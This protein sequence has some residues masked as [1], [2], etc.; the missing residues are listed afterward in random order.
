MKMNLVGILSTK[1]MVRTIDMNVQDMPRSSNDCC[2]YLYENVSSFTTGNR[3]TV[4]DVSLGSEKTYIF[5]FDCT[6]YTGVARVI[7]YGF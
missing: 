2:C 4:F 6:T 7:Y 3:K 5:A 1:K